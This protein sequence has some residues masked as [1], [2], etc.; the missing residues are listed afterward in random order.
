[1]RNSESA[2]R[3]PGVGTRGIQTPGTTSAP[4]Q[5]RVT[6]MVFIALPPV[7]PEPGR[8]RTG[9]SRLRP[10]RLTSRLFTTCRS[11]AQHGAGM[12]APFPIYTFHR[13]RGKRATARAA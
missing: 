8:S 10:L 9:L 12:S 5:L 6:F 13:L 7:R 3:V 2:G 4:V 1:V 11:R